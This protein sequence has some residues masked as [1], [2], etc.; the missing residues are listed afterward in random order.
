MHLKTIGVLGGLGP[1]TTTHFYLAII[2]LCQQKGI[3]ERPP[4]LTWSIPLPYSLEKEFITTGKGIDQYLPFL[5]E[6][7][8]R[9]EQGG[10]DF[11]VIPCNS[12]HI[13]IDE[14]RKSVRIPVLSIVEETARLLK[15]EGIQQ[16]GVLAT[17]ATVKSHLYD[18][19]LKAANITIALPD[20]NDQ[21]ALSDLIQ[22]LARS[23]KDEQNQNVLPMLMEKFSTQAV[24]TVILACTDLQLMIKDH[25]TIKIYDTM[26]ILVEATV[27]D[28]V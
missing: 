14:I 10:A 15:E 5:I 21:V 19:A 24:S 17:T 23:G 1:E 18:T 27:R 8:K 2:S 9:L 16:V 13:L 3:A 25:P 26:Q 12:V 11:I 7:A 20:S 4:I 28:L 22:Q 6:G